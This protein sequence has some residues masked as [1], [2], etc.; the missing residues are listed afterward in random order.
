MGTVVIGLLRAAAAIDRLSAATAGVARWALLLNA[1]LICGNAFIRKLFSITW[2]SLFDMQ[3]H[4]FAIAVLLMAAYTLQRDEHVRVDVLAGRF[5]ARGM[6]WVDLFGY[7]LVLIP[8]CAL[9]VA[10]TLPP[11]W[12]AL[13]THETRASRESLSE[14]PAW[15]IKGLIP[16][17]FFLLGMQAVAEAIR[18]VAAIRGIAARQQLRYR[19]FEEAP[20]E[21]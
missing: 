11:A 15:I 2:T 12:H 20:D 18:C 9:V 1:L 17:G 14:L 3:W 4:F 5:G 8:L 6:A 7:V 13:V 10:V 19:G 16:A 21:R